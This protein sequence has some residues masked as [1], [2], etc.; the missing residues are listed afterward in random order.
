M[1]PGGWHVPCVSLPCRTL[2][3]R[4]SIYW[5][6]SKAWL[7]SLSATRQST[8]KRVHAPALA[9]TNVLCISYQL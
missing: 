4:I 8:G 6:L 1:V 9:D 2:S 5:V 3:S 7:V